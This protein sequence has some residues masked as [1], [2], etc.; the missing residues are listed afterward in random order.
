MAEAGRRVAIEARGMSVGY[1]GRAVVA[2][3][4]LSIPEGAFTAIIGPNGSGKSTLLRALAGL[5]P[6]SKGSLH[7]R[8]H[9][10]ANMSRKALARQLSFLPQSPQA[11]EG[12]T[13]LHLVRQGRYPHRSMLR[14]W[15]EE[16]EECCTHA[17]LVT[18]L[19][20]LKDRPLETLSGGQR[21]R[22]WI[23]M[24][25]AQR[26]GILLLDEPTAFLDIAH[27]I[28]VLE[29]LVGFVRN[30]ETTTVAIIHDINQAVRYA[31][32]VI[33]LKDGMLFAQGAPPE[34]ITESTIAKV[35]HVKANKSTDPVHGVPFFVP[36]S[37]ERP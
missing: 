30:Q 29:L 27:Q 28:D 3:L 34:A 26:A 14:S 35:F 36:Y 20:K 19:S 4:D 5:L 10:V 23:A 25:L 17:L 24:T 8:G 6:L 1:G 11:P 15:S 18:G 13:P 16:D 33:L 2:D 22:A 21:Q 12:L 37:L 9:S 7:I 31:D 32:H